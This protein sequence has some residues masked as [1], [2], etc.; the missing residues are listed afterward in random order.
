MQRYCLFYFDQPDQEKQ[1]FLAE[2]DKDAIKIVQEE[3]HPE[4]GRKIL[5]RCTEVQAWG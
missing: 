4:D 1:F 3:T 2:G 5:W